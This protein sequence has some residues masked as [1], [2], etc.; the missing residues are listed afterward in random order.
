MRSGQ[1]YNYFKHKNFETILKRIQVTAEQTDEHF[2]EMEKE[3]ASVK[4]KKDKTSI[5]RSKKDM[6][7]MH[8]CK[9]KSASG[10]QGLCTHVQ[11]NDLQMNEILS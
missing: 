11:L 2:K 6:R 3:D 5:W 4:N 10:D 9:R 7:K 1:K 8:D